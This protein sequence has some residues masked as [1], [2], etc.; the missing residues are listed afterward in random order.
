MDCVQQRARS[1]PG[2]GRYREAATGSGETAKLAKMVGKSTNKRY[3]AIPAN[4]AS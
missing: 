2:A 4:T 3:T 1:A